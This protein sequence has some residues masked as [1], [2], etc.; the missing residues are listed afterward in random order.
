VDEPL[1]VFTTR[2]DTVYGATFM[3]SRPNTRSSTRIT[4]DGQRRG[5]DAYIAAD[6]PP[7]RDR[8]AFDRQGEDRRLHRRLR[9]QPV[10]RRPRIPIWIADYVLVTYGTGA[11]MAV[12][13]HDQRDFDFARSTAWKSSPCSTMPDVDVTSR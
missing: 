5:A 9:R 13:A 12:P 4:T 2:P 8:A 6:Q 3:V 10:Q 11:I 7:D 1:T